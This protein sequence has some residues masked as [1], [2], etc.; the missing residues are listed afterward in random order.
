MDNP[1]SKIELTTLKSVVRIGEVLPFKARAKDSRGKVLN[2]VPFSYAVSGKE[3][4]KGAG[5]SAMIQADGRFVAEI[6]GTYTVLASS[7]DKSAVRT[8]KAIPRN[9]AREIEMIGHG[10]V[11]DKHTS[12]FWVWEGVDGRDYAVTG[13]W[14]GDGKA[15]FWDVTNPADIR[16]IDSI[17]VDARTV[18]DVKISEDGT[19]CIISREG[20]SSRK[21]GIVILDVTE[22]TDVK[23]HST[24]T[25][26]LTGGVHNLFI[27]EDHVYAL[28]NGQRYDIINIADPKTPHRVGKFE[29]ENPARAIHDVWIENGIA[30]SSNWNDGVIMVDVGNGIAGG[31]P[32]NPVEI[33]RAAVEGDAN[34]AA[35]P[36]RSKTTGK[37]YIIAGDEIFPT[38]FFTKKDADREAF[39][40]DGYLHFMD[41][42]DPKNPREVARYQVPEAGSH[43]FWVED[44]LL[45]IGYYNGGLRI[46]D[47]SGDLMGDLYKQ[48]REVA[49][50]IPKDAKGVVPNH[51]MTWGAQPHKGHIF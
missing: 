49:H 43:N 22:P 8:V 5:A 4:E 47:I 24:F 37:F 30:Y 12:D 35:F 27:Y 46:V 2:N 13:T 23:I 36:Y 14:G 51:A 38:I 34:H 7:G 10:T 16:K 28:S 20:A 11:R 41:F 21:N 32:S 33:A 48:G 6:P 44:D 31:S 25:E 18:N 15:Y 26:T 39:N 45:Y 9:V 3:D 42:T 40:P 17:Q 19:I 1:V 50:Y 29:I